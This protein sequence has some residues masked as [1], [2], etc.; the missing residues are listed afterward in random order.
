MPQQMLRAEMI[1]HS[2]LICDWVNE[3]MRRAQL[4]GLSGPCEAS[5]QVCDANTFIVTSEISQAT[6][7]SGS[8]C[9]SAAST[10]S[11][12]STRRTQSSPALKCSRRA[13]DNIS[14]CAALFRVPISL[15]PALCWDRL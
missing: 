12:S 1:A 14:L 13:A 5:E 7:G 8:S 2:S 9:L 10:T 3:L 6:R 11:K 4:H 15:T